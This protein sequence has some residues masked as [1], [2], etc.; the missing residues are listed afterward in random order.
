MK[1]IPKVERSSHYG[2]TP[3]LTSFDSIPLVIIHGHQ[4]N[5]KTC[6]NIRHVVIVNSSQRTGDK[7]RG[8]IGTRT[9]M[10]IC[11]FLRKR[12]RGNMDM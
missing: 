1:R 3:Y 12:Q 11:Y 2:V 7:R 8:T 10:Q 6:Q 4:M 9:F 5:H